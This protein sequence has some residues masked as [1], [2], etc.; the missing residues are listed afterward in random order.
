MDG[1]ERILATFN[2]QQTDRNPFW[3]GNPTPEV[4]AAIAD[5]FGIKNDPVILSKRLGDDMV[6]LRAENYVWKHP[7]GLKFIDAYSGADHTLSQGGYFAVPEHQNIESIENFD[8]PDFKYFEF[9][10]YR[11]K[12]QEARE[13]GLATAGGFWCPFFHR[14]SDLIG[15]E[16]YFIQMYTNPEFVVALTDKVVNI[17]L[18]A[19][20]RCMEEVGDLIDIF[21]F[22]NDFGT[23]QDLLIGP[24]L[25]EKF[26]L[27]SLR[28]LVQQGKEYNKKVLLHSCGA[29][30]RVIP[31]LID[32]GVDGIHPL[33]ALASNMDAESLAKYSGHIIF[34]GAIDTQHLLPSGTPDEIRNKVEYLKHILGPGFV[35]SPSHEALMVDVPIE[36]IIALC[37]AGTG[38]KLLKRLQ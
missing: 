6:W 9:G 3:K 26:V 10:E 15:M 13:L 22:G 16:D 37:E 20:K 8:W 25:F 27:P 4:S 36:N 35:V 34:V 23:Q 19:N 28:R 38:K 24:D 1:R 18:E 7:K 32:A 14:L 5:Y 31:Q 17:F 11:Q 30:S 29:I 33:Q 12:L 2:R 21:F